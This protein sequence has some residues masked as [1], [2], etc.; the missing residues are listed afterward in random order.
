[1]SLEMEKVLA[2]MPG[3]NGA[4]A[5]VVL[6][7]NKNHKIASTLKELFVSDKDKA[8]KYAKILYSQSCLIAGKTLE[9]PAEYC[10]LVCEFM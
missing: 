7:I 3:A 5:T 10:E 9:N 2:A 8:A 6:E 4:K 1:M